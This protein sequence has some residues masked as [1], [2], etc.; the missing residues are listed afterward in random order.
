VPRGQDV[1]RQDRRGQEEVWSKKEQL[2]TE[3]GVRSIAIF[4]PSSLSP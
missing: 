3:N 2:T 1:L 4:P